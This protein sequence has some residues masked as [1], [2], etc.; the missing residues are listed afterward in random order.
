MSIVYFTHGVHIDR[1]GVWMPFPT[2]NVIQIFHK[3]GKGP[4]VNV[5]SY[6]LEA[7]SSRY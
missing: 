6:T 2:F 3:K 7:T 4:Q 5:T 1:C